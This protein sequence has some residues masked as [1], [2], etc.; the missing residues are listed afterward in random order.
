[1]RC[2]RADLT[3]ARTRLEIRLRLGARN[4]FHHT[5]HTD[6][7]FQFRPEKSQRSARIRREFRAFATVVVGEEYKAARVH[8]LQ[9]NRA[10]RRLPAGI[11]SRERHRIHI[12]RG[13]AEQRVPE[14]VGSDADLAPATSRLRNRGITEPALKFQDGISSQV[15]RVQTAHAVF[16]SDVCDSH[17]CRETTNPRRPCPRQLPTTRLRVR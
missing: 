15:F 9:E 7:T 4:L 8:T 12:R 17:L 5:R 11:H 2:P 16:A 10:G 13:V 14:F 3:A 1:M 6:L